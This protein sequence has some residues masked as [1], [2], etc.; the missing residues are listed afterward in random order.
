[1]AVMIDLNFP[2]DQPVLVGGGVAGLC[3]LSL[4]CSGSGLAPFLTAHDE[5]Q[6]SRPEQPWM[7]VETKDKTIYNVGMP[8]LNNIYPS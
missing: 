3:P 1:M 5:V 2:L 8:Q 7:H 4:D 6:K